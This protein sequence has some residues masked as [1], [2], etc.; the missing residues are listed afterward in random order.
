MCDSG[1]VDF[2]VLT[3]AEAQMINIDLLLFHA[4]R[5]SNQTR[6]GIR[7]S[8]CG[9]HRVLIVTAAINVTDAPEST[10]CRYKS[11]TCA[12]THNKH[13]QVTDESASSFSL[14]L[15]LVPSSP[16]VLRVL[17]ALGSVFTGAAFGELSADVRCGALVVW[18]HGHVSL[19]RPGLQ[20]LQQLPSHHTHTDVPIFILH[21]LNYPG[22]LSTFEENRCFF[23][24]IINRCLSLDHAYDFFIFSC[25]KKGVCGQNQ[26]F[27]KCRTNLS[28]YK[29]I[30]REASFDI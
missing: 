20:G 25:L 1:I 26:F 19:Q 16:D 18:R 5:L 22:R 21:A 9:T 29:I 12:W 30:K 11:Y 6:V 8:I 10:T 27:C 28:K 4:G 24:I 3:C 15:V 13:G 14:G 17:I 2:V 7:V 23:F